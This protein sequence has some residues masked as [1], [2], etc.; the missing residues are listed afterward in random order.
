MAY[1]LDQLE[2]L[3]LHIGVAIP[4]DY[5]ENKRR[6]VE[7]H[8]RQKRVTADSSVKADTWGHRA[9]FDGLLRGAADNAGKKKF[10]VAL[11]LIDQ[12]EALLTQ[13]DPPPPAPEAA[14]ADPTAAEFTAEDMEALFETDPDKLAKRE[15]E[16]IKAAL[17]PALEE[18]AQQ[19]TP[20][21]KALTKAL[22]DLNNLEKAAKYKA[23][24]AMLE[25]MREPIKLALGSGETPV[26]TGDPARMEFLVARNKARNAIADAKSCKGIGSPFVKAKDAISEL[27]KKVG[28]RESA[29]QWADGLADVTKLHDQARLVLDLGTRTTQALAEFK[30]LDKVALPRYQAINK[31]KGKKGKG[32]DTLISQALPLALSVD[33]ATKL[34]DY[35]LAYQALGALAAK[36]AEIDSAVSKYDL[37]EAAFEKQWD[38]KVEPK[39]SAA[40]KLKDPPPAIASKVEAMQKY[41]HDNI[42]PKEQAGEFADALALLDNFLG[43]CQAAIDAYEQWA[44]EKKDFETALGKAKEQLSNAD[45][46]GAV[47]PSVGALRDTY[48]TERKKMDDLVAAYDFAAALPQL[49]DK[50]LPAIKTFLDARGDYDTAKKAY[51]DKKAALADKLSAA[52]GFTPATPELVAL[53]EAHDKELKALAP[54][55]ASRD[56]T[57]ATQL[58]EGEVT[59]TLKALL[60]AKQKHDKAKSA[61]IESHKD[62]AA[63]GA[64]AM[65]GNMKG[66]AMVDPSKAADRVE[67]TVTKNKD[68]A[69]DSELKKLR[70]EA[71]HIVGINADALKS[72]ALGDLAML[73]AL[74]NS[75][76]QAINHCDA[77]QQAHKSTSKSKADQDKFRQAEALR[78]SHEVLRL[79]V[80]TIRASFAEIE[81]KAAQADD[82]AKA[83]AAHLYGLLAKTGGTPEIKA[84]AA[85]RQRAIMTA[86]LKDAKSPDRVREIAEIIGE[87]ALSLY[88]AQDGKPSMKD[89]RKNGSAANEQKKSKLQNPDRAAN[90]ELASTLSDQL[91]TEEGLNVMALHLQNLDDLDDGTPAGKAM[92][93]TLKQLRDDPKLQALFDGLPAPKRDN[94]ICDMLRATLGKKGDAE[95][96]PADVKKAV[97]SA[98]LAELRQMDVGSCF[99]T[100]VAVHVHDSQPSMMLKDMTEMLETGKVTRLTGGRLVEAPVQP[101]M[102]DAPMQT[103]LKL[104][105]DGK[106]KSTNGKNLDAA[107]PLESTPAFS[108][109]FDGLG[110]AGPKRKAALQTAQQDLKNQAALKAAMAKLPASIDDAAREKLR[111]AVLDRLAASPKASVKIE[112]AKEVQ[113]LKPQPPASDRKEIAKSAQDVLDAPEQEVTSAELLRQIAM[114][115]NGISD[116]DLARLDKMKELRPKVMA[117]QGDTTSPDALKL[118]DEYD[119][120]QK[121]IGAKAPQVAQF[122]KDLTSAQDGYLSKEDNRL[123]RCWEYTVSALAEQGISRKNTEKLNTATTAAVADELKA[124]LGELDADD[125]FKKASKKLDVP[126]IANALRDRAKELMPQILQ[127][128]YDA[129]VKAELSADGS[130]SRGAFYL[131]DTQ[132]LKDPTRWI[133]IDDQS[134]YVTVVRGIVMLAWQ[135]LF[136]REKDKNKKEVSRTIADK[137]ADRL[138][139]ESFVNAAKDKLKTSTKQENQL[140]WQMVSGSHQNF[141]SATYFGKDDLTKSK[142]KPNNPDEL[143]EFVVGTTSDMWD[144]VKDGATKDP[145]GTSVPM[146]NGPHAFNLKPGSDKL[147]KLAAQPGKTGA[148]KVAAFKSAEQADNRARLDAAASP[149][150]I[151]KL[152]KKFLARVGAGWDPIVQ[153]ELDKLAD[154]T[155]KQA[156]D[157]MEKAVADNYLLGLPARVAKL[158]QEA[159][160]KGQPFDANAA[161]QKLID[162]RRKDIRDHLAPAL[163][164]AVIPPV[165]KSDQEK[166]LDKVIRKTGIDEDLVDAVR[167]R[168]LKSLGDNASTSDLEAAVR[169]AMEAEGV[170]T[171]GKMS[172]TILD[173]ISKAQGPD[174][175]VFADSNWGSGAHRTMFSMVVNPLNGELEMW[176]MNE[177]GSG[178]RKMNQKTWVEC[179][180]D[181]KT[182]PKEFSA[183]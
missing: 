163:K 87:P 183:M 73:E 168:A 88:K 116:A 150:V 57:A 21:K 161:R 180:W 133:K 5:V 41:Y 169:K 30:K 69:G 36:M 39:L 64:K 34:P 110:I 79:R 80:K 83:E 7:F 155:V 58:L 47:I 60:A 100:S 26:P 111:L 68:L 11:Q 172:E 71:A 101:R 49:K 1:S 22:L 59:T 77:Y 25:K 19:E 81:A 93:R 42:A 151:A 162:D 18:A 177:D 6:E 131:F 55:E 115:E 91:V 142:V 78:S 140:P 181:I 146:G 124:A 97:L 153:K 84:G 15:W 2:F 144:K 106:L 67:A 122:M 62:A 53:K 158:Q 43:L 20:Q 23:A 65:L 113:K 173:E 119:E 3:Q 92:A 117:L 52:A 82:L 121:K 46:T 166:M 54:L 96:T 4:P 103:K 105:K 178:M 98:M 149:Q 135:E 33:K 170:A 61:E 128:G 38:S 99:G 16:Q 157:A 164:E 56:F 51:G 171:D 12:A 74:E 85:A 174:G 126:A 35:E 138:S 125:T 8:T 95:L 120:L 160:A 123:L 182:E 109:A 40:Q 154:P 37:A 130:S 48:A 127:T 102:S 50:V 165:K 179:G 28:A 152:K 148:E 141:M 176:Q 147:Q 175:L 86:L 104:G 63:K 139:K 137:L 29:S 70:E 143:A 75:L 114:R 89:L 167:A 159:Q 9:Q 72:L 136:E 24:L 31:L 45:G 94:P 118:L 112:L 132:G 10:D 156:S 108:S 76:T 107:Q 27:E 134:K 90:V 66:I 13:P 17:F 129:S 44:K 145:E 32:V 14:A